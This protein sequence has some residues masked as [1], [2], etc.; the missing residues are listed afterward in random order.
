MRERYDHVVVGSGMGGLAAAITL[1]KQGRSV[2]V[3][4][5]NNQFGGNLQTF[6]RERTIFDTGVHYLGGLAPGHNLHQYFKYLGIMDQLEV[7]RLSM[8]GFDIFSFD[9]DDRRYR[10]AQGLGHFAEELKK[11]FPNE[12]KAIDAYCA[13]LQ[14]YCSKFPMYDLRSGAPYA[15]EPGLLTLGA[16]AYIASLT[17]NKT[18]RA[19][20]GG[21]NLLYA[22]DH[23]HS[24]FYV[25]ALSVY[26][27][28]QSAY[29]VVRGGSQITKLLV[30]ELRKHGGEILK[31]HEVERF[32]FEGDRIKGAR[33][34]NGALVEGENFISNLDPKR[35]IAMAGPEHF[36]KP[37]VKRVNGMEPTIGAFC[38]YITLKPGTFPYMDHNIYHFRTL[39]DVWRGQDYG[40]E[41]WPRGYMISMGEKPVQDAWAENMTVMT[42]MKF[43]A[44]AP[45]AD[46]TNT[47]IDVNDRGRR[48]EE[49]KAQHAER[50]LNEVHKRLPALRG[51]IAEVYSSTPLSYRDYIHC[52]AG[53]MYGYKKDVNSPLRSFISSRTKVPNLFITGQCTN[54]HGILGVTISA[55]LTCTEILEDQTILEEI[56]Q[57]PG[58]PQTA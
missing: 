5:K 29:R 9:G 13:K 27:Y 44:M 39:D 22:G 40:E 42:Y 20:L 32:E 6:V 55:L 3:L 41:D 36:R 45:W 15:D 33:C 10:H 34:R 7:R 30:R 35:T 8:D 53:G 52:D 23:D 31:H 19:V 48:Y 12:G 51:C 11:Q 24:P 43:N 56:F 25:H 2:C 17:E 26:S 14:E 57:V 37:Y 21:S 1:A 47:V 18:L 38:L 4:E 58:P 54:M 46:S 49:F 16:R 50:L 28:I